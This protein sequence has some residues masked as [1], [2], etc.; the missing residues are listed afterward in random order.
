MHIFNQLMRRI[1]LLAVLAVL[2]GVALHSCDDD[3][4]F[5]QLRL[6]LT[7]APADYQQVNIDVQQVRIKMASDTNA[8]IDLDTRAGIYDLLQLRDGVDTLLA[9]DL[10]PAG[11][12]R[13][14]RLILGY[15]NTVMVDS[16]LHTLLT[17]SAHSSGYKIK[18]N[19]PVDSDE[20]TEI[21]IDFDAME[22]VNPHPN[23]GY[24]LQ[25]VLK[26]MP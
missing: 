2:M 7:D 22:S 23:G 10:I 8:F 15:E 24:L 25:P 21:T 12:L 14:I 13:E 5:A 16:T 18:L 1:A 17:P 19:R 6:R 4:E 20:L 3:E 26:L 11:T 9:D